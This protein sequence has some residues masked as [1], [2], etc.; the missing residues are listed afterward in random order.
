MTEAL[1]KTLLNGWHREN[2][3]RMVPFGGWDMPVNYAPGI[4]AEHLA[5]RKGAGLFDISH[6]GRFRVSGADALAFLQHTLTYDAS[7]LTPG[8][9]QY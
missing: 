5:T 1:N 6:M 9:A 8:L 3:A 7:A 2:G 4:L